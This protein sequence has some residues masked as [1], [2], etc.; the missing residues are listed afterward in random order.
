MLCFSCKKKIP[1]DSVFC[2]ECGAKI[3]ITTTPNTLRADIGT[4]KKCKVNSSSIAPNNSWRSYLFA[5]EI[6]FV[7][8][9]VVIGMLLTFQVAD[10]LMARGEYLTETEIF[11]LLAWFI[12]GFIYKKWKER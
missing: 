5:I 9:W 10:R 1:D 4:V 11:M 3:Q 6:I 8:A 12:S 7:L 2:P